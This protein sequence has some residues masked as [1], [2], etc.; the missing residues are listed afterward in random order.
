MAVC[1]A[2]YTLLACPYLHLPGFH[3]DE[4]LIGRYALEL[5]RALGTLDIRA[6][7]TG[8]FPY[9]GIF[10]SVFCLP[11]VAWPQ[12]PNV[13]SLR[14]AFVLAGAATVALT[15]LLGRRW[16]KWRSSATL[17]ALLLAVS[18][19]F[20]MGTRI[21]AYTGSLLL[22]FST[23]ALY[24]LSLAWQ[25]RNLRAYFGACFLLGLG[26]S[27]LSYF[28][29]VLAAAAPWVLGTGICGRLGPGRRPAALGA[30]FF[31]LGAL[32]LLCH[33]F[34]GWELFLATAA[35]HVPAPAPGF[36]VGLAAKAQPFRELLEGTA[37]LEILTR[38]FDP[39]RRYFGNPLFP[40]MAGASAAVLG[41]RCTTA[42]RNGNWAAVRGETALLSITLT[43]GLACL[44]FP[45]KKVNPEYFFSWLPFP[46]LCVAAA[47]DLLAQRRILYY[48]LTPL[49]ALNLIFDGLVSAQFYRYLKRT[50]G[51]D[52][53]TEQIVPLARWL[54]AEDVRNPVTLTWGLSSNL[55]FLGRLRIKPVSAR[56]IAEGVEGKE[57]LE[58]RVAHGEPV[59]FV[60]RVLTYVNH[61][62]EDMTLGEFR[63]GVLALPGYSCAEAR[64][65]HD[66][67]G[68]LVLRV[69]RCATGG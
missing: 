67:S 16:L 37:F 19:S 44:A 54:A 7:P 21:G 18:P 28:V 45:L 23:A 29:F 52:Q 50:G 58:D 24:L 12:P 69:W 9:H 11:F 30:L 20:L 17:G 4:A 22:L 56:R 15:Y 32:P 59:Y 33:V 40:L 13:L 43:F 46:Q 39:E 47:A 34:L 27:T 63:K 36:P 25:D 62:Q 60:E 51:T 38:G 35:A 5:S 8:I 2:V 57:S 31:S 68:M 41:A 61:P 1:T 26:M 3:D 65:F 48:A 6:V 42:M 64:L 66:R 55:M 49:L 53:V 10:Q 14:A